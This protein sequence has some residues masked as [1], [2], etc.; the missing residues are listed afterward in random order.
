[1]SA[2]RESHSATIGRTFVLHMPSKALSAAKTASVR[3]FLR[4]CQRSF[5]TGR[6]G[7]ARTAFWWQMLTTWD[8][9][10]RAA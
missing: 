2:R 1:M 6:I 5:S 7:S 3:R 8:N 10:R 4:P 9:A